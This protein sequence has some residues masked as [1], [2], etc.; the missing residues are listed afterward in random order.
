MVLPEPAKVAEL[1]GLRAELDA[2][3]ERERRLE[4]RVAELE[5]QLRMDS[6]DSGTPPSGERIGA[7]GRRRAQR[8]ERDASERERRNDRKPGGQPGHPG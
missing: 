8:R 3:R 6:A 1:A 7:R 2:A 4:L 5:R